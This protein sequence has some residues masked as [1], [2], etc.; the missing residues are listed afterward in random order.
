MSQEM[1]GQQSSVEPSEQLPSPQDTSRESNWRERMNSAASDV[2]RRT[3][4]LIEQGNERRLI[5]EY[6]GRSMVNLPLTIAA[7]IGAVAV[8]FAPLLAVIGFIGALLAR[9]QARVERNEP[10]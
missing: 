5:L 10:R 1:P 2:S 9:V 4:E 8:I 6:Q 7:A 3:K